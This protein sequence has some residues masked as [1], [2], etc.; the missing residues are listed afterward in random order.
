MST[1][2]LIEL[3]HDEMANQIYSA[4][5]DEAAISY[6][7]ECLNDTNQMIIDS[8]HANKK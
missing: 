6:L 7:I 2:E 1:L 4:P 3:F 5:I 8:Y